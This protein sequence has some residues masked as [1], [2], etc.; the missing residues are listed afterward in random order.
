MALPDSYQEY[1]KREFCNDIKCFV[2]MELNKHEAGSG[3]YEKVRGICSAACQFKGQDF[4]DWLKH[5]AFNLF[6]DG[7]T[8]DFEELRKQGADF[9]TTWKLHKWMTDNGYELGKKR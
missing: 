9:S 4:E 3:K 2:Q 8:V 7:K 5:N 1:K 6:K